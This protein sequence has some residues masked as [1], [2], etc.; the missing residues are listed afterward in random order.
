MTD[1]GTAGGATDEEPNGTAEAVAVPHHPADE[2]GDA[3]RDD[4][5]G[6]SDPE[7]WRLV[8]VVDVALELPGTYPEVVLLEADAP[9]RELRIPVGLAE[10]T[11][12]AYALRQVSTPRPMTHDLFTEMLDRHGVTIEAVRVSARRGQVFMAEMDT[13][14]PRGR[15]VMPCRP[16]D[17]IALALR[18]RLP[19]PILVGTWIFP[20]D[21]NEGSETL[22]PVTPA[23]PSAADAA[24]AA[25]A[26]ARSDGTPRT[27]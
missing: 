6:R 9:K 3:G 2:P 19:V 22:I 5:T 23:Q 18:Q 4:P 20:S 10:G 15:Q 14:G 1:T 27:T 26:P 13:T 16:S 8:S 11:A 17:A 21:E 25:D 12:I 24:D 7:V